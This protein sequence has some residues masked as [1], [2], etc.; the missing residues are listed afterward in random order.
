MK[1]KMNQTHLKHL[2]KKEYLYPEKFIFKGNFKNN[3]IYKPLNETK[4]FD[5]SFIKLNE[6]LKK[7]NLKIIPNSEIKN[8]ILNFSKN[9]KNPKLLRNKSNLST[10][11]STIKKSYL[12]K[13]QKSKNFSYLNILNYSKSPIEKNI[14]TSK[15]EF[16]TIETSKTRNINSI[17]SYSKNSRNL[18]KY[19]SMSQDNILNNSIVKIIKH[20]NIIKIKETYIR[21]TGGQIDPLTITKSHFKKIN[22]DN[23]FSK[24]N[25]FSKSLGLISLIGVIDGH[26]I[27]GHLIAKTVKNFFCDYFENN[28]HM[29]LSLNKD[30]YYT[31]LTESFLKCQEYLID[32][33]S[34]FHYNLNISGCTCL[35]L[36]Y[37]FDENNK[38]KIFCANCGDCKCYLFSNNNYVPLSYP[39]T[40]DRVSENQRMK[41]KIEFLE[42]NTLKEQLKENQNENYKN[43]K[44][45]FSIKN[46]I[47][48]KEN[49]KSNTSNNNYN[50]SELSKKSQERKS[51]FLNI[52]NANSI[53]NKE[54]INNNSEKIKLL[55][56]IYL[57]EFKE[58]NLSRSLGDLE[59]QNLG[60]IQEPE[61][62]ECDLKFN[63]GKFIVLGTSS[64]FQFI[65]NEEINVIVKK[66]MKEN[67]GFAACKE[68]EELAR[69]RW[70]KHFRKIEDI[71][72]IIVFLDWKK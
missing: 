13:I 15:K 51:I 69:E 22:Q 8:I 43:N 41:E 50:T 70:K 2:L 68:L 46:T 23:Y 19:K 65:T 45:N 52:Q 56:K 18:N 72:I 34:N 32:N 38:N 6:L 21:S 31:I 53:K 48:D 58:L 17:L 66:Y 26:G 25:F 42:K 12:P 28:I 60:I 16:S 35:I 64:L 33:Q 44:L 11:T 10:S 4:Q 67:K 27:H 62:V 36:F 1:K 40:P 9:K 39:H 47:K 55:K 20:I 7:E 59:A 54:I 5:S 57:K 24:I 71:T 3:T 30:N 49:E 29:T 14:L 63:R 61:I 37:P